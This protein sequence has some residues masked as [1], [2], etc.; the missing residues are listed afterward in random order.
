MRQLSLLIYILFISTTLLSQVNSIVELEKKYT[1][2]E[3]REVIETAAQMINSGNYSN[4][5]LTKIYE[6][7]GMAHF[8]LGEET[9]SRD[10]FEKLLDLNSNYSMDQNR[11][12]PK[13][14]S[15]F[16]DIKVAYQNELE[17][18]RPILDSLRI[19]K[20]EM[21]VAQNSYKIAVMK[22]LVL[23]GWGHFEL[24]NT[25][26][27]I[28]YTTLELSCAVSAIAYIVKSNNDRTSYLNETDKTLIASRYEDYNSSYKTK[29]LFLIA[30]A[31][32]WAASQID[33]AFFTETFYIPQYGS[34]TTGRLLSP[35]LQFSFSI[36]IN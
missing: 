14:I 23:P 3:Y 22:N 7:K 34:S 10:S 8:S 5:E 27:G 17:Q 24:G 11:I 18:D 35:D 9:A 6:L 26:K 19:I 16:N 13:I 31:I 36:P 12:S 33:L 20:Q 29:N 30:T 21:S 28:I 25:T 2:F 1:S 4:E 15:F 32:V